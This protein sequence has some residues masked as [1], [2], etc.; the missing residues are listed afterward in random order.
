MDEEVAAVRTDG[1]FEWADPLTLSH[2]GTVPR[3]APSSDR[4]PSPAPKRG[5]G[6]GLDIATN[7]PGGLRAKDV[8]KQ[9]VSLAN[10]AITMWKQ[11]WETVVR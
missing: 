10:P 11:G 4:H 3:P 1:I 8:D 6:C 9:G 7:I 5:L 2:N